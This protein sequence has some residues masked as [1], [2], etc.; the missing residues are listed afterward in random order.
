MSIRN[1]FPTT[2]L[3]SS[4]VTAAAFVLQATP[5]FL[6]ALGPS[7]TP[8]A[9]FFVFFC[10]LSLIVGVC[11]LFT[12]A[13]DELHDRH[14]LHQ[15]KQQYRELQLWHQRQQVIRTLPRPFKQNALTHAYLHVLSHFPFESKGHGRDKTS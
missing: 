14:H 5:V 10:L 13:F 11:L 7:L 15:T 3:A 8:C 12:W 1:L 2:L 4:I 6:H 9:E